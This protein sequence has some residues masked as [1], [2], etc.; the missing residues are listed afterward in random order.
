M[1]SKPA[2]IISRTDKNV[3]RNNSASDDSLQRFAFNKSAAEKA[4]LAEAEMGLAARE[5]SQHL[6]SSGCVPRNI[7]QSRCEG[8]QALAEATQVPHPE[9]KLRQDLFAASVSSPISI[10][11]Q[12]ACHEIVILVSGELYFKLR[13]TERDGTKAT[14]KVEEVKPLL[15]RTLPNLR[16]P[17][18]DP[19]YWT[20]SLFELL[21]ILSR[22]KRLRSPTSP[23]N[24]KRN[25]RVTQ[26]TVHIAIKRRPMYPDDGSRSRYCEALF[27]F[28]SSRRQ[29]LHAGR[30][31]F[32][33][34]VGAG[35]AL[36]K[37]QLQLDI[38]RAR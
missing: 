12:L 22:W 38:M 16:Q 10:L 20:A 3:G 35:C 30:R 9:A 33:A 2:R 14:Q 23:K 8:A 29:I 27:N 1:W 4:D 13:Q 11:A 6:R 31:D 36:T 19:S 26:A 28:L 25:L 32:E 24:S 21:R 7:H 15:Q 18:P 17:P 5:A 34:L 37:R